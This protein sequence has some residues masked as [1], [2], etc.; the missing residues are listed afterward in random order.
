MDDVAGIVATY[1][2]QCPAQAVPLSPECMHG[3][4]GMD[5]QLPDVW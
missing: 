4:Q 3:V 2:C 1:I 5:H